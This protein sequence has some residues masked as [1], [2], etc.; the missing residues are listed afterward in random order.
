[1]D[2]NLTIIRS[3]MREHFGYESFITNFFKS[4]EISNKTPTAA[5]NENGKLYINKI[6]METY[7]KSKSDLFSV[8][9]HELLHPMFKHFIY[10]PNDR[11]SHIG[12]D[13]II[14]ATISILYCKQ[15]Y[16][17]NFFKNFYKVKKPELKCILRPDCHEILTSHPMEDLYFCLYANL[18]SSSEKKLST[19]DVIEALKILFSNNNTSKIKLLGNHTGSSKQNEEG[20]D[21]GGEGDEEERKEEEEEEEGDGGGFKENINIEAIKKSDLNKIA[22]DIKKHLKI[23]GSGSV[24]ENLFLEILESNISLNK[25]LIN[26]MLTNK[27]IDNFKGEYKENRTLITPFPINPIKRDVVY[28]SLG[29]DLTYYK[30]ERIINK[31]R[32]NKGIV[33]YIDASGSILNNLGKIVGLL[34]KNFKN[35]IKNVYLFSTI[36]TEITFKD[37]K[38]GNIKTTYGTDFNCIAESILDNDYNKAIIITDGISSL[39]NSY[40]EKLKEKKVKTLNIIIEGT[41]CPGFEKIGH[42]ISIKEL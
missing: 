11:L 5:I 10:D 36:V 6:F 37:L 33:V 42:N 29:F 7:I 25:K 28:L 15:S 8:I 30:N 13:A 39:N 4:F 32:N 20:D 22:E 41:R 21:Y 38:N 2:V 24:L 26:R 27:K 12:C 1:M 19:Y 31:H 3:L 18:T 23:A 14:N 35:K 40:L 9:M 34:T 17:G 16:D